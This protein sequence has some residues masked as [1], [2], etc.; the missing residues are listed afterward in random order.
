MNAERTGKWLRQLEHIRGH[1]WHRYSIAV[2]IIK[3]G[4]DHTITGWGLA[5][6]HLGTTFDM[7]LCL[8]NN[9]L[10]FLLKPTSYI[11]CD[12]ECWHIKTSSSSV[13]NGWS[14][15]YARYLIEISPYSW[16]FHLESDWSRCVWKTGVVWTWYRYLICVINKT[17]CFLLYICLLA[18]YQPIVRL[19]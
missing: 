12:V 18:I 17:H 6:Y 19:E 15:S 16:I 13:A 14:R 4:N 1:L 7:D 8:L 5:I 2:N 11:T 9:S 3:L 10:F